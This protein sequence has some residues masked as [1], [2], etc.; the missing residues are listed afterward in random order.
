MRELKEATIAD[1]EYRA[2]AEFRHHI[3]K[4]LDFSDQLA[5]KLGLEPQQYQLMLAIKG[6]PE[7]IDPTIGA[8]AHQ[9]QIRHHS[10]VELADRAEK[11]GL[12]ERDRTGTYVFLHLTKQGERILARAVE[13][14]LEELRV[15]GPLLVKTLQK[16]IN[17][18]KMPEKKRK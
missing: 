14:R 13:E 2:L 5:K 18:N 11:N 4:Y 17:S 3:R 12:I 9:L 6:L 7:G 16:L 8:L 10:A 15:A 1:A